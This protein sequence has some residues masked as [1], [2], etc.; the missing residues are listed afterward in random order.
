MMMIDDDDDD[1][2]DDSGRLPLLGMGRAGMTEDSTKIAHEIAMLFEDALYR[3]THW[4]KRPESSERSL[5]AKGGLPEIFRALAPLRA[6]TL[7][8]QQ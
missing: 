4:R 2:D 6:F 7:E 5:K 8:F 1:D 3:S